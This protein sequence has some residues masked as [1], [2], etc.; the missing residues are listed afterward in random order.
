MNSQKLVFAK[1][2]IPAEYN[3]NIFKTWSKL[4]YL[5]PA[6]IIKEYGF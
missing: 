6:L 2:K 1:K 5:S 3:L 4:A